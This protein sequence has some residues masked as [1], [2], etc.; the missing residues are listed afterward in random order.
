M[1]PCYL[2]AVT[3][4]DLS[5]VRCSIARTMNILGDAWTALILRDVFVGITRFD[6]LQR[7]LGLSRKVLS[8][9]LDELVEAG[10]LERRAYSEHPPRYDYVPTQMGADLYPVILAVMAWGDRWTA[11]SH[12][13]PA[14]VRHTACGHLARPTV[15]CDHCGEPL[16]AADVAAESG[17]GGYTGRGTMV[18][19]P[20]L[21]GRTT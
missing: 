20:L 15:T 11:G 1:H 7:D 16:T 19:G 18:L 8:A 12:G 10:V 6:A 13:P 21:A 9:R 3:R 2:R 5:D 17:P 14:R 4:T